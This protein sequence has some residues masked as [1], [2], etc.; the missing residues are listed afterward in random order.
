MQVKYFIK[1]RLLLAGMAILTLIFACNNEKKADTSE[2][3]EAP[4]VYEAVFI[5]V[6]NTK[7]PNDIDKNVKKETRLL[8]NVNLTERGQFWGD[9]RNFYVHGMGSIDIAESGT[10]YF[11][12]TSTG[13]I[14]F[15]LN[16]KEIANIDETGSKKVTSA[17]MYL[18]EGGT[19]F[20]FEYY[21]GNM[22][23]MLVLEW[24]KDGETY[25]VVPDTVFSNLD[26]LTVS[27][28]QGDGESAEE[29]EAQP[30]NTLT[31][32]EKQEGWKLLF[33]GESTK[34]WHT[35]NKPGTIGS[36][37]VARDGALVF[38]G[39]D[40]FEFFVAGRKIEIGDVDKIADGGEDIVS[41]D[42][43]ENFE[44][45][46]EWKI[47]KGGNNG[48]FYMIK[49]SEAYDEV[50]KTSPEM[51]VMDNEGHKDGL[52]FKHRAGD[53]YDLIPADPV[54]VKPFG[55]WNKVKIVKKDGK[56]EQWLNGTKVV[57]FDINSEEWKDLVAKS[58][59]AEYE[60]FAT[61]GPGRIG[62]Q[63]HDNLVY[64][65]NVKIKEL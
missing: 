58:K 26:K 35:Y 34:G 48:I 53:L 2:V 32:K 21:P 46:L 37:W 57:S 40:R 54:R 42:A 20:E 14:V 43:Y 39:R 6:N 44:L 45:Q 56:V 52:I 11:K 12:L 28:W 55:E 49:E 50:W 1:T 17:D 65:K 10:Y 41:D 22:D 3:K 29:S 51:Q 36:K 7:I 25:E 62:F 9:T 30:D 31:D 27:P 59:F 47:S 23:P 33:D 5:D 38:E 8:S 64:Y 16:N 4:G 61:P 19:V 13:K 60:E 63:D 18:D 24:S 15:R